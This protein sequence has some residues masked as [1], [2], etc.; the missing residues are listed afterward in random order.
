MKTIA[1]LLLSACVTFAQPSEEWLAKNRAAWEKIKIEFAPSWG[2]AECLRIVRQWDARAMDR[3]WAVY[4]NP[5]KPLIYL[6]WE[7]AARIEAERSRKADQAAQAASAQAARTA[8]EQAAAWRAYVDSRR[9]KAESGTSEIT[10]A[11]ERLRV[12]QEAENHRRAIRHL[13][14]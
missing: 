3:Q 12:Q 9:P 10:D 7:N 6:R 11:L 2:M 13:E 14:R 4:D 5:E 8:A 1:L